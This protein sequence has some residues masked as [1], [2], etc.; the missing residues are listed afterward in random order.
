MR[1]ALL[2]DDQATADLMSL[3]LEEAGHQVYHFANGESFAKAVMKEQYDLL[4]LDWV[5]PDITGDQILTWVRNGLGW[6]VPIVFITQ[7]DSQ[8]D[9][10]AALNKGAD[11][12]MTK[13]VSAPVLK[14]RISAVSRR[15]LKEEKQHHILERDPYRIDLS[16]HIVT[17]CGEALPLTQRE[18]DLVAFFFKNEGRLL[19][20]SHIQEA[21]WGHTG[22]VTTRT[23]D[24]HISR[25]RKKLGIDETPWRLT[26][27]YHHGYRLE[28]GAENQ[29]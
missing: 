23:I 20:R 10:V 4:I 15:Y 9:I 5:L 26:A 1:I 14:A 7:K 11:D 27:V 22:S 12:F 19:T 29:R 21:V 18:Y 25:I 13:P 3:W 2:E 6:Q 16:G 24:I 17:R 8:E 28:R